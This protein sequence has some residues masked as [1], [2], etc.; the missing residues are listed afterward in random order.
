MDVQA[1][2]FADNTFDT[3]ITSCVFCSVPDPIKGLKEIRRVCKNG[4]KIIMLEHMRSD[5][6]VTGKFMDLINF[7]PLHIW[8]ANINRR[9]IGNLEKA[10]FDEEAIEYQDIWSDI[11][12]FIEIKNK[13]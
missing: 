13:K 2:T 1:L 5:K 9:T 3:V 12:K 4:G 8:G 6:K 7:I 11:V 10:G